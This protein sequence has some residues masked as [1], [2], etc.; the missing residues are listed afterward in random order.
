MSEI[1]IYGKKYRY[2][3]DVP[4]LLVSEDGKSIY[5]YYKGDGNL[6]KVRPP[7]KLSIKKDKNGNLYISTRDYGCIRLDMLVLRCFNGGNGMRIWHKDGNPEN[8]DRNN[9]VW[10]DL[11]HYNNRV[12]PNSDWKELFHE[13]DEVMINVK[14]KEIKQNGAIV[15][16]R[17]E[18][19]DSD[20]DQTVSVEDYVYL[21]IRTKYG[22][23]R[24]RF[25]VT[26]LLN[27]VL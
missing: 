1:E 22:V 10:E 17:N 18:I 26:Q 20:I 12:H 19:Y 25:T 3:Y 7:K 13:E 24:Q 9:L 14:T 6:L 4:G 21:D 8:C 23:N 5:R 16:T 2:Y 11:K 15:P 27:Q